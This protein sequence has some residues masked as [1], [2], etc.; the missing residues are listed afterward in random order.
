MSRQMNADAFVECSAL[1]GQ[2]LRQAFEEAAKAAV[3]Y[4]SQIKEKKR[5]TIS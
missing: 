3:K 1:S 5:C 2:N 4:R